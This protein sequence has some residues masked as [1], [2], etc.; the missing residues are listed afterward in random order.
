[1]DWLANGF[2]DWL[3]AAGPQLDNSWTTCFD[4]F[5]LYSPGLMNFSG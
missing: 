5:C 2:F 1:M 4:M 3:M